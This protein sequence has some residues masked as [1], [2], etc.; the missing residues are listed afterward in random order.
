MR[1]YATDCE[2]LYVPI[3]TI[4]D[5]LSA[6]KPTITYFQSSASEA[7]HWK[8]L[9]IYRAARQLNWSVLRFD[10]RSPTQILDDLRYWKPDAVIVDA[11]MLSSRMVFNQV[12]RH[13]PTVFI[14]PD[15]RFADGRISCVVQDTDAT[16]AAA[17]DELTKTEFA[18][19]AFA[20]WPGRPF[21]S[22]A[23]GKSFVQRMKERG[24][25]VAVLRPSERPYS[26]RSVVHS[27]EGWL[28]KLPKPVG[29]LA[30]TD[31]M[32]MH[33][34]EAADRIGLSVPGE[35]AVIGVDDE[36]FFCENTTPTLSSISLGFDT[37]GSQAIDIARRLVENPRQKPIVE[38]F[39]ETH[40][41]VR[42]TTRRTNRHD[43]SVTMALD[44]IRARAAEGLSASEVFSCF[45][46][47]RRQAEQRFR[48]I[49]GRSV[50]EEIHAVQV[51]RAKRLIENPNQKLTAIH[52]LC[53]HST[54]QFFQRLFKQTV[55]LTMSEYRRK[56][57]LT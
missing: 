50:L 36:A 11:V 49:A 56:I 19:F 31:Q 55:G 4:Y 2:T 48:A 33:V 22:E 34:V 6:M 14:D 46:C 26:R 13:V 24:H 25:D 15:L 18:S 32:S 7:S 40:I 3:A 20:S 54:P 27:L 37:A 1:Q 30:A 21:W 42:S 29:I 44:L 35:V 52:H 28:M 41:I 12:F 57:G 45:S 38:Q 17:A 8:T 16:A 39:R 51:E 9:G 5:I 43:R 10:I 23:R 53:G 47:S